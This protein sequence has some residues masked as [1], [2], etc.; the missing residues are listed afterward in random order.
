MSALGITARK[1]SEKLR[2]GAG[3]PAATREH[4]DTGYEKYRGLN[5]ETFAVKG[6]GAMVDDI[7]DGYNVCAKGIDWVKEVMV[8]HARYD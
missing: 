4:L 5:Q 2:R 8:Q 1:L 7:R 6:G 3:E